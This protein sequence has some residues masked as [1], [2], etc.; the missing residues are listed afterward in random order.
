MFGI[1]K[2]K[3]AVKQ[4]PNG[5][6]TSGIQYVPVERF[7]DYESYLAAASHKLWASW[8]ASDIIGTH[9]S[10]TPYVIKNRSGSPVTIE[11]LKR[12]LEMPNRYES[13]TDLIYKIVLHVEFT[14]NSFIY[15]ASRTTTGR[16]EEL[17]L[18]NPKN[19]R[20][21]GHPR[22]RVERY[23]YVVNGVVLNFTPDEIMHIKQP[24]PNNEFWGIGS[25]EAAELLMQTN[26]NQNLA[27]DAFYKNGAQPSAVMMN[28][29]Y[30][31]TEADLKKV[32]QKHESNFDSPGK[33]GRILWLTGAWKYQPLGISA[34]ESQQLETS[35][36]TKE[37]IF[38]AHGVPLEVAGIRE[39]DYSGAEAAMSRFKSSTV[40]KH[41]TRIEE[42]FNTDLIRFYRQDLRLC[43]QRLGMMPLTQ[44]AE[45]LAPFLD[46]A[47]MT[48]N[49]ARA[50]LGL[51]P[52]SQN[53]MGDRFLINQA[54]M[55]AEYSGMGMAMNMA[56]AQ[57][58][59]QSPTTNT[60][61]QR[62]GN[63]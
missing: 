28:E 51:P 41:L 29:D 34:R 15:K 55:P 9:V 36:M 5:F 46:R 63:T 57:L 21:I 14:G 26:I 42:R 11:P 16:P 4:A 48:P 50:I 43:F 24:H 19:V 37:D 54:L 27:T 30:Q 47:I 53:P 52:D 62:P 18:L 23:E 1:F 45:G 13:W 38:L 40:L 7:A 10:N 3:Q 60:N 32:K 8:K 25:I 22:N 58:T 6:F 17:L 44:L 59:N 20:I 2:K 12:L 35:Q 39:S 31:G 33:S 61:T 49:E 56:D